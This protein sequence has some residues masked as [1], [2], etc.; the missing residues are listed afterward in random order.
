MGFCFVFVFL[1]LHLQH[2][3]VPRLAVESEL[4]LLAYT[5]VT[6]TLDPNRIY[7]LCRNLQQR[8]ILKPLSEA[9]DPTLNLLDIGQVCFPEPQWQLIFLFFVYLFIFVFLPFLGPLPRHMEVPR[10]GVESE[11]Q[12]PAYTRAT[13]TQD[14]SHV[15]GSPTAHG[16]AGSLTH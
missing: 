6:A 11:L 1:W 2:K 9:R 13:A 14:L 5:T 3:E 15:C 16:N 12:P 4:Q 8:W 10:L 7:D